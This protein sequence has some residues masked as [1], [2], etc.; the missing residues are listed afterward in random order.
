MPGA[1]PWGLSF[2]SCT[3]GATFSEAPGNKLSLLGG[4]SI[5]P[6]GMSMEI[7]GD[8]EPKACLAISHESFDSIEGIAQQP[9]L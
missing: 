8:N 3:G 4:E 6:W 5:Y 7:E 1:Q 2:A 9:A